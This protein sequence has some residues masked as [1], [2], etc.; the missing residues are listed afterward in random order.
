MKCFDPIRRLEVAKGQ[1][2]ADLAGTMAGHGQSCA[3]MGDLKCQYPL[4]AMFALAIVML[5][6]QNRLEAQLFPDLLIL[7]LVALL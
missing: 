4:Q 2:I 5:R 1:V 7:A 3:I 6:R